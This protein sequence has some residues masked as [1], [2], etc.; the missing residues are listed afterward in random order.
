[1]INIT[2]RPTFEKLGSAFKDIKLG[3]AIQKGIETLA[4]ATERYSKIIAPK[5]TGTMARSID[6]RTGRLKAQIGPRS[7]DYAIYVHEGTYKMGARPFMEWGYT[8]AVGATREEE[9]IADE[10]MRYIDKELKII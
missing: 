4:Y 3:M 9:L 5:D 1:M 7:V 10:V 6:V 2:A 8:G